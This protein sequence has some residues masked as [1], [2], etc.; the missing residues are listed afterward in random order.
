MICRYTYITVS[1]TNMFV[2]K[3][4]DDSD[5]DSCEDVGGGG[6]RQQGPPVFLVALVERNICNV[7]TDMA[8]PTDRRS[9]MV[10]KIGTCVTFGFVD[11]ESVCKKREIE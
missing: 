10:E 4:D 1:N 7:Q 2:R 9:E 11:A 8:I 3:E 5:D 6:V